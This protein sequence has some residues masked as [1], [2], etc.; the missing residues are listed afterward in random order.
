MRLLRLLLLLIVVGKALPTRAQSDENEVRCEGPLQQDHFRVPN[1]RVIPRAWRDLAAV[2]ASVVAW[3][4]ADWGRFSAI[5]IPT[6]AMMSPP[7]YRSYDVK[8]QRWLRENERP[9]AD[10]LFLQIKTIPISIALAS[11][12][13]ALFGTAWALDNDEL[14]EFASLSFEAL[15]VTQF[16]HITSK[17]L[18]GR[19]G[20]YQGDGEGRIYGLTR[21]SFPGGTPSGHAA[22]TYAVLTV[23]AEYWDKLPLHFLAHAIGVYV[24]MSLVYERQHFISD[25][26][27]GAPM[28]YF[29][30][31]WIVR[32]RSSRYR[33][34]APRESVWARTLLVP[35]LSPE[36][37]GLMASYRF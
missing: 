26:I 36:G 13:A 4:G 15:L 8:L 20:P 32:H 18:L 30:G 14:F 7:N 12:G 33:C 27:W 25:V 34:R 1:A 11:Y 31:R 9:G 17:L 22:T 10:K 2:P 6:L 19:E 5:A 37:A 23:M 3:D 24:S 16:F 21:I 28:G 29:I 35:I